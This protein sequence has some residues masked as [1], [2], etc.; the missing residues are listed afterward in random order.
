[1]KSIL[2]LPVLLLFFF[3][4]ATSGFGQ[5]NIGV[6]AGMNLGDIK[7]RSK[8]L[9]VEEQYAPLR[10]WHAGALGAV[11]ISK[12]FAI[13]FEVLFNQKGGQ[14][15]IDP[16]LSNPMEAIWQYRLSYLSLP[17]MFQY[18]FGPISFEAGPE[19]GYLAN[20]KTLR[21]NVVVDN[22]F[23]PFGDQPLDL[24]L[25][26]GFRFTVKKIFAEIRWSK[27][28][29]SIGEISFT[30]DSGEL[31]GYYNHF[32]SSLQV[33]LGYFIID[34]QQDNRVWFF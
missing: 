30:N 21:N 6:K 18:K 28:L 5:I 14:S 34:T 13:Q 11:D 4:S 22:A 8:T 23:S 24:A 7:V 31:L 3:L 25:N 17:V 16:N 12:Q 19:V 20:F 9:L 32:T 33:S 10:V 1:M 15:P 29:T 27:S 2:N 26:A